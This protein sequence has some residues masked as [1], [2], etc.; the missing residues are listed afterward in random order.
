[1]DLQRLLRDL[2]REL[3]NLDAAIASLERLNASGKRRGRPPSVLT[4]AQKAAE[5]THERV[6][7]QLPDKPVG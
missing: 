4:E 2:R 7:E 3:E 1:M 5:N 6:Q